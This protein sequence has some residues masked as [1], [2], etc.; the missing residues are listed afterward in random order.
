MGV[1][2]KEPP[3]SWESSRK[4]RG[5]RRFQ[6]GNLSSGLEVRGGS[7]QSNLDG[8]VIVVLKQDFFRRRAF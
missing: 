5:G 8:V 4:T 2:R 7:L 3:S 1:L 6:T